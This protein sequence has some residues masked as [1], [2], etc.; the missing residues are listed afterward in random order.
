MVYP[1]RF[2]A[3]LDPALS[4]TSLLLHQPA[5]APRR[6]VVPRQTTHPRRPGCRAGRKT[7]YTYMGHMRNNAR[8]IP[9][10]VGI[11]KIDLQ[12]GQRRAGT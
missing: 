8:G 11:A 2:A 5:S 12:A 3:G 4:P 1:S 9:E 10:F 7:R 6:Y